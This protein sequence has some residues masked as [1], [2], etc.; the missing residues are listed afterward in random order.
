M[1]NLG[2]PGLFRVVP[3]CGTLGTWSLEPGSRLRAAAPNHPEALLEEPQAF[4]AV[5]EKHSKTLKNTSPHFA[6]LSK[7]KVF[8]RFDL[9]SFRKSFISSH[10][11]SVGL[12]WGS[13]EKAGRFHTEGCRRV[14]QRIAAGVVRGFHGGSW[15]L[16]PGFKGFKVSFWKGSGQDW[17]C[18]IRHQES[19]A[20]RHE[21]L[22]LVIFFGFLFGGFPFFFKKKI[23][24]L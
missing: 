20:R 16:W 10:G 3:W 12:W 5:G 2:E 7:S 14:F 6:T 1:L 13:R 8:E 19:S 17:S 23:W 22:L 18:R 21:F 24:F 11:D 9:I 15:G 4:Q